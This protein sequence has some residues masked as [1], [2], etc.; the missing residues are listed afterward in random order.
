MADGSRHTCDSD[1]STQMKGTKSV[2]GAKAVG[3]DE[4]ENV[5]KDKSKEGGVISWFSL[6]KGAEGADVFAI[7]LGV[8]G[9]CINGLVFPAFSFVF[10]KCS[11]LDPTHSLPSGTTFSLCTGPR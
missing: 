1:T 10:G 11:I 2:D 3:S 6:Y 7:V 5:S 4:V 8:L 9:A